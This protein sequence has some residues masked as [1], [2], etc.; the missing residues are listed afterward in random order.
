MNLIPDTTQAE[1]KCLIVVEAEHTA[2]V[3]VHAPFPGIRGGELSRRPPE[4]VVA[5]AAETPKGTAEANRKGRKAK[6]VGAVMRTV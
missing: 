2:V 3:V 6:R 5:N 1:T 4:A